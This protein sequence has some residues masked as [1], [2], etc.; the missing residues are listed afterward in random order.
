MTRP[1]SEWL[2]ADAGPL[3]RPYALTQGRTRPNRHVFDMISMVA[4]A[5]T[6][7]PAAEDL[8][9]EHTAILDV[10]KRPLSIAELAARLNLPMG[11]ISVLAG[12]LLDR[13]FIVVRK[14]PS[15]DRPPDERVLKEVINGLQAL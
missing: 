10:S 13:G 11:V 5:S 7:P 15:G 1:G 2:D 14:P 8:T 12:D 9:P 3:V 6:D 4:A